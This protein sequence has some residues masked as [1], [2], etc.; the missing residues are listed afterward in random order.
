MGF[1]SNLLGS[2]E[3]SKPMD[4]DE[5]AKN[6]AVDWHGAFNGYIANKNDAY[7]LAFQLFSL[8]NRLHTLGG[9]GHP[10]EDKYPL[11]IKK[12]FN[13]VCENDVLKE[14]Y[15]KPSLEINMHEV[16]GH[17]ESITSQ[18][19]DHNTKLKVNYAVVE[20]IIKE[21]GLDK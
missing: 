1:F 16:N 13:I 5:L 21:W 12:F 11:L 15:Q 17:F 3:K 6:I 8:S 18:L 4:P 2:G 7:F 14:E 9:T 20:G 10:T 19:N